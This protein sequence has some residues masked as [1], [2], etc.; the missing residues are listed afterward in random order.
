MEFGA[1]SGLTLMAVNL[2]F[3]VVALAIG[4]AAGAWVAKGDGDG[5]KSY[6]CSP[7]VCKKTEIDIERTSLAASR[8]RDLASNMVTDVGEH[9]ANID[10][11]EAELAASRDTD[12]EAGVLHALQAISQANE[13]LRA[14]LA[15]AEE[16]IEAQAHEIRLYESD[17]RTDSLTALGNRR[18]FDDEIARRFSQMQ[19]Q[20][21][22]F[23]L[24]I[25]DVD[26]FKNFNDTH[27]HQAGDEVLRKVGAALAACARD[28]DVPC[29]YGGEEFAFVLPATEIDGA[30]RLAERARKKIEE[31]HV[32]F[33]GRKLN[34][35]ISLGVAQ[36][37]AGET[38]ESLIRR[39]D[40][41][42]YAAKNAGRNRSYLHQQGECVPVTEAATSES[43]AQ[44]QQAPLAEVAGATI[45]SLPNR[46][47][48][49]EQLRAETRVAQQSG[50]VLTLLTAQLCAYKQ[51]DEEYGSTIT[52]LTLDSVAQFLDNAVREQ[53]IL[54]KFDDGRFVV[55]MPGV[56]Q[57]EAE[58]MGQ[59]LAKALATCTV[60]LGDK[61]FVLET[62]MSATELSDRD[63]PVSFMER[64]EEA[65]SSSYQAK[66]VPALA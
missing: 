43:K 4:F 35:T 57:G 22:Q 58:A 60:P 17:A 25:L 13:N 11:I 2:L 32:P 51:L 8:L 56:T 10:K 41:A 6:D 50:R 15:K 14:K 24:V 66:S 31:M 49:L 55:L 40:D 18:A 48:F 19:R 34:V 20:S 64:A 21:T 38:P 16:Q 59:R 54:A 27:G 39:A 37:D 12:A 65:F 33:D 28:M 30:C 61:K 45:D 1:D 47:R 62:H 29:R 52:R 53:D 9:S 36:A 46:T 44:K 26:H 23:S 42:L 5:G 63:T 3:A 7:D